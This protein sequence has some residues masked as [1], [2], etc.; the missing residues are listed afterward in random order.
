MS[1]LRPYYTNLK[2]PVTTPFDVYSIDFSGPLPIT[3]SGYKY[4]LVD[5]ENLTGWP[6]VLPTTTAIAG[7][8]IQKEVLR[9][10]GPPRRMISYK[11]TC[12]TAQAL[13]SFMEEIGSS[14]KTVLEYAPISNGGAERMVGTNMRANEKMVLNDRT[15]S[16]K[17]LPI[18]LYG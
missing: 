1:P 6:I 9:P 12:F 8:F 10:Y 7:Q 13:V 17:A 15:T 16:D 3:K 2:I 14:W 18:V 4:L 11:A 5:V